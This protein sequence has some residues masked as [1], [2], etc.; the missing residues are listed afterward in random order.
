M[1]SFISGG[2]YSPPRSWVFLV[3]NGDRLLLG[4]LLDAHQLGVYAIA[5]LMFN[6][7]EQIWS[8]V[9]SEV[10]YPA[11]SETVRER[12]GQATRSFYRVYAL[13]ASGVYL[14]AGALMVAGGTIVRL[15]YDARYADAS[16]MLPLL[17]IALI[18]IPPRAAIYYLLAHGRAAIFSAVLAVRLAT[19]FV[20]I[21]L[22]FHLFGLPGAL[23]GLVLSQFAS[24]PLIFYF[25]A[26]AGLFDVRRELVTLPMIGVGMGAG[27]LV[28][29]GIGLLK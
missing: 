18:S 10:V 22:G 16:W 14:S 23:G 4:G 6:S 29:W 28:N 12:A 8:T 25:S 1:R 7:V 20:A 27:L 24:V 13:V 26:R 19:S 15:L 11:L 5:Y 9:I 3:N 2:G 17:S 21:P